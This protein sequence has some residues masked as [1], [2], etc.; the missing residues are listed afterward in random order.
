MF[1]DSAKLRGGCEHLWRQSWGRDRGLL[2][3]WDC[4]N[5]IPILKIN[6]LNS[7]VIVYN[8][9]VTCSTR[10]RVYRNFIGIY[11]KRGVHFMWSRKCSIIVRLSAVWC[12]PFTDCE[13]Y[14]G[15]NILESDFP[16]MIN[17]WLW[18]LLFT[19]CFARST[20]FLG[21]EWRMVEPS[22]L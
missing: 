11:F 6:L 1:D 4:M 15:G 8:T 20:L 18:E 17:I 21:W 14:A 10:T 7:Y 2:Q 19:F 22:S 3:L 13:M 5:Y 12:M 16:R 9:Q